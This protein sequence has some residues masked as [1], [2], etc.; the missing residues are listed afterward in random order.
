MIFSFYL[1]IKNGFQAF[2]TVNS[3][4]FHIIDINI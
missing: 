3:F 2:A 4:N 1:E